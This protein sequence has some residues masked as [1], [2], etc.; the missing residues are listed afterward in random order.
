MTLIRPFAPAALLALAALSACSDSTGSGGTRPLSL[1]FSTASTTSR[2]ASADLLTV[3]AGADPI[4]ITRAQ[5]V[6]SRTEL[7]R[8]GATCTTAPAGEDDESECPEVKLGPMLVDLPVDASTKGVLAV[9]LPAGTYTELETRIDAVSSESDGDNA[10]ASAFL[11][12]NPQFRGVSVRVEGTY[13]GQPFVYTSAVESELELEFNP[14]VVIDA[15]NNVTVHVDL[16][17][18]FRRADGT[19]IDPRTATAGSTNRQVVDENIKRSFHAFGDD[20][21]DGRDD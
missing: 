14:P 16:A 9:S 11:A 18:W 8:E 2:S 12:A 10:T 13:N 7:E 19:S 15:A 20:D 3:T 4:V 21:R 6:L 17:S 1:S 5:I